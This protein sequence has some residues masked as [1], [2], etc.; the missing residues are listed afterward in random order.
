MVQRHDD[1]LAAGIRE[2]VVFHSTAHEF[3]GYEANLPFAV[4]ADP[5][6]RLYRELGVEFSPRALLDPRAWL[7]TLRGLFRAIREVLAK[8]QSIET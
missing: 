3:L 1:I 2:V 7:P 6:R 4:I 8:R 5:D